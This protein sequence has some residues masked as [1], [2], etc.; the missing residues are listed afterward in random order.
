[1][2]SECA[3]RRCSRGSA[4]NLALPWSTASF[5]LVVGTYHAYSLP[6]ESLHA[7]ER[8]GAADLGSAY[9]SWLS[10]RPAAPPPLTNNHHVKTR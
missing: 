2:M 4:R 3:R 9:E 8:K 6:C 1:M 7:L 10:T 5:M